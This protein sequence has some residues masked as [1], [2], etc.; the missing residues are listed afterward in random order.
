MT[1]P[2]P[3]TPNPATTVAVHRA[4]GRARCRLVP[5][6][7]GPRVLGGDANGARVALVATGALLLGGDNVVIEV[8]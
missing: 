2:N 4:H 8:E 7:F 1:S 5:G 6:A 3:E